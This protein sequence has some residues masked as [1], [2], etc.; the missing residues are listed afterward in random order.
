M[1][2]AFDDH[3]T[4]GYC[5]GP[6][7]LACMTGAC[8]EYKRSGRP[9]HPLTGEPLVCEEIPSSWMAL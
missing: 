7:T 6:L 8:L 2:G 4:C 5:H 1:G 9:L 3:T